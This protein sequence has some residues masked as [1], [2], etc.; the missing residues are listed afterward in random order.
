MERNAVNKNYALPVQ[1]LSRNVGWE[2]AEKERA[3]RS[4]AAALNLPQRE[5]R[6]KY[7]N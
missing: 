6:W 3:W 5:G 1:K 7:T 4:E 2:D